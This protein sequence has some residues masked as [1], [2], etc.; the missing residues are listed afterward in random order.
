MAWT[1]FAQWC[2]CNGDVRCA[3]PAFLGVLYVER[4][5]ELF[6]S[7]RNAR[8]AFAAAAETGRRHFS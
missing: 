8:L 4:V 3:L 1:G 5:V 7:Q 6:V 2:C